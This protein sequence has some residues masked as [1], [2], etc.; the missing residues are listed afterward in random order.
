MKIRTRDH[1]LG[2]V[3]ILSETVEEKRFYWHN[4]SHSAW[5]CWSGANCFLKNES[6]NQRCACVGHPL[7][8][9]QALRSLCLKGHV[10]VHIRHCDDTS[11]QEASEFLCIKTPLFLR[12]FSNKTISK[13]TRKCALRRAN[14]VMFSKFRGWATKTNFA[15][16]AVFRIRTR[17][18]FN[19]LMNQ[20]GV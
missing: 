12:E 1:Q 15:F 3:W 18:S 10:R 14:N 19:Y 9:D 17:R 7:N 16:R 11:W 20:F 8:S 5:P 6:L 2:V 4:P 13:K